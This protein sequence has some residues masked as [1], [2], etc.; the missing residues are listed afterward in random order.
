VFSPEDV[1]KILEQLDGICHLMVCIMYG[2]GL[3]ALECVSIRIKDLDFN[4]QLVVVRNGKGDEDRVTMLPETCVAPLRLQIEKARL[5]HRRDLAVPYA[6]TALPEGLLRKHPFASSQFAWQFL[7]PA[8]RLLRENENRGLRRH[9]LDKSVIQR[10]VARAVRSSGIPNHGGC[11]T[12]RHSF[13]TRLLELGYDIRTVQRLLGHKDV[14]TTMI[15]THVLLKKGGRSIR[16]P[17]DD[18]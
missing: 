16:S 1:R 8:S 5:I 7:F 14:R 9:H 11:H 2:A 4:R 17:L 13:A 12:F 18:L 10:A 15:Y 6:G 3:R